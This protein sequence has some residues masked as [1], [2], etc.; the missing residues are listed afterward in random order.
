VKTLV[1]KVHFDD[2]QRIRVSDWIVTQFDSKVQI[3][4][5]ISQLQNELIDMCVWISKLNHY[6]NAKN[7]LNSAM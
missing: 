1:Y 3:T 2:L 7:L 4:D 5:L 6:S